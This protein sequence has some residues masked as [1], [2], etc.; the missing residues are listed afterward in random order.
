[1][2]FPASDHGEE[3][4]FQSS[5]VYI[6]SVPYA[7]FLSTHRIILHP[8]GK[9]AQRD[10]VISR[11]AIVRVHA[12]TS[13]F[14]EPVMTLEACD[15]SGSVRKIV[16]TFSGRA[17]GVRTDERDQWIYAFLEKSG[18]HP[19]AAPAKKNQNSRNPTPEDTVL[20]DNRKLAFHDGIHGASLSQQ[21]STG[22]KA[23]EHPGELNPR[24]LSGSGSENLPGRIKKPENSVVEP[25]PSAKKTRGKP[26]IKI[27]DDSGT[28]SKKMSG[29]E[30]SR[31]DVPVCRQCGKPLFAR[32]LFCC[33]CGTPVTT[34]DA[35]AHSR[36]GDMAEHSA[37]RSSS[38]T[39]AESGKPSA[40]RFID[41][42]GR[43]HAPTGSALHGPP[44]NYGEFRGTGSGWTGPGR[45]KPEL[46]HSFTGYRKIAAGAVLLCAVILIVVTGGLYQY[47]PI[48]GGNSTAS[49]A[50]LQKN[51]VT[52]PVT[53]LPL[54]SPSGISVSSTG[55]PT[56]T[57]IAVSQGTE[58]QINSDPISQ[59]LNF[60]VSCKCGVYVRVVSAGSWSGTYGLD[61]DLRTASY[62]GE[63][64][65]QIENAQGSV[66]AA[67]QKEDS[68]DQVLSVEIYNNGVLVASGSSTDAKGSVLITA[69]V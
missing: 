15:S 10:Y 67:F 20:Y 19:A 30:L 1:M 12:A 22:T 37:G 17:G 13:E 2:D 48:A 47:L 23:Q 63:K 14:G 28:D 27:C 16:L 56:I 51:A 40:I 57:T 5:D 24:N 52:V 29:S 46:M 32:S 59:D 4:L 44:E 3:W 33:Y 26:V 7:A 53:T 35:V 41:P 39:L 43:I 25:K 69:D 60:I 36:P 64:I 6:K 38:R 65:F 54:N 18:S 49:P 61:G 55:L 66:S 62:T 50:P 45:R 42:P 21:S 8:A 11:D 31:D 9:K 34:P 58:T 68:S